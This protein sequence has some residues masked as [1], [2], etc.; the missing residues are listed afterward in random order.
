MTR[1]ETSHYTDV[2]VGGKALALTFPM[3]VK[4]VITN[5]STTLKMQGSGLY[6]VT[7]L[8]WSGGGKIR[9]VEVSADGGKTWADAALAEPVLAKAFTRFRM[10]WKWDGGPAVLQS[11]AT[12]DTG[13]VQPTRASLIER[14]G[15]RRNYHNTGIQIWAVAANGEVTNVYA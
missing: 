7:G 4:S 15:E 12:D 13:T 6:E 10:A 1:D 3:G 9:R 5:P 14:F 11:R 8:A 2:L